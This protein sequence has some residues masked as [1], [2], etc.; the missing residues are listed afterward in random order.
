M[1]RKNK[2]YKV[3]SQE[4]GRGPWNTESFATLAEAARYIKDRWQGPDYMDGDAS[5]HT[6]Y[7][8]YRLVGFKLSDIGEKRWDDE[9][10]CYEFTFN[11]EFV[12]EDLLS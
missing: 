6:D 3:Q 11:P 7:C 1:P 12:N 8:R 2:P 10:G 9:F 5:F 4:L